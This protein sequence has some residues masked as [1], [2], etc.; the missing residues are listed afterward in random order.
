[1]SLTDKEI[2]QFKEQLIKLKKQLQDSLEESSN[3][4]KNSNSSL[5]LKNLSD[6]EIEMENLETNE[7]VAAQTSEKLK[8]VEFALEKIKEGTYGICE[9]S[10]KPIPKNRLK[11]I[12]YAT[13]T[14]EVQEKLEKGLL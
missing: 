4:M 12:P 1:M 8:Q 14:K 3:D 5:S 7:L 6:S 9:F 10:K 11:A 13:T 2:Q